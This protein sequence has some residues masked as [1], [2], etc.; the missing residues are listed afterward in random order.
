MVQVAKKRTNIQYGPWN[1]GAYSVAGEK[2]LNN[3]REKE[4]KETKRK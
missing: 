2:L 3:I 4:K 1:V